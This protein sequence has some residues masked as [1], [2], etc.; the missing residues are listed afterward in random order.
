MAFFH[1]GMTPMCQPAWQ[2]MQKRKTIAIFSMHTITKQII[3]HLWSYEK[4][5]TGIPMDM[6]GKYGFVETDAQFWETLWLMLLGLKLMIFKFSPI[7]LSSIYLSANLFSLI[8]L[9]LPINN[10]SSILPVSLSSICLPICISILPLDIRD[11]RTQKWRTKGV[12]S[13]V[14]GQW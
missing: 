13:H 6:L 9:S 5:R 2:P 1:F 11:Q 3:V 8:C 14:W 10:L 4:F 12:T 7:L